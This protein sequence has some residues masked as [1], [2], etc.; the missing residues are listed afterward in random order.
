MHNKQF[1]GPW[2]IC[3]RCNGDGSHSHRLGAIS[4]EEM[5]HDWDEEEQE[6]YFAGGYDETCEECDGTGKVREPA[7]DEE[8]EAQKAAYEFRANERYWQRLEAHACGE[9]D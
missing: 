7:N 9:R 6:R 5:A 8:R 2:V 3:G 4:A 1:T